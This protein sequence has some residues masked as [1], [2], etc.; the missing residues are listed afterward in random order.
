M[1]DSWLS[2]ATRALASGELCVSPAKRLRLVCPTVGCRGSRVGSQREPP[3]NARWEPNAPRTTLRSYSKLATLTWRGRKPILQSQERRSGQTRRGQHSDFKTMGRLLRSLKSSPNVRIGAS[4]RK[5]L[6]VFAT[7]LGSL[8][9]FYFL[10]PEIMSKWQVR[11]ANGLNI[12]KMN[13]QKWHVR[14][15]SGLNLPQSMQMA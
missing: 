10:C 8:V 6:W 12:P 11:L 13:P 14:S 4:P 3:P 2:R 1:P 15:A 9:S 7:N 5:W